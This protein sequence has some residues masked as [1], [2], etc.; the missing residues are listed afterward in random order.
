MVFT[1]RRTTLSS[2]D[3]QT[4]VDVMKSKIYVSE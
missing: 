2:K 3:P 4:V 1:F